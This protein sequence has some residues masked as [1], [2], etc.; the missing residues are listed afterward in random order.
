MTTH[1]DARRQME[2]DEEAM[3]V[4]LPTMIADMTMDQIAEAHGTAS[5]LADRA[6]ALT[7]HDD[8]A[9]R[10]LAEAR[11]RAET[12]DAEASAWLA[13]RFLSPEWYT[14]QA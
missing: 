13:T 1:S 14:A 2:A 5:T 3:P 12:G 6:T 4:R 10:L 8:Y 11:R 7:A 9:D